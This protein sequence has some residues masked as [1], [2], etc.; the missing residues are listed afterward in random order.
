MKRYRFRLDS[1]LRVRR[2]Q[3]ERARAELLSANQAV[4]AAQTHLQQR[5]AHLEELPKSAKV[6]STPAFLANQARLASIASSISMA[7][8]AR[9]VAAHAADEKRVAWQVTAQRVEGLE[10]LD[11]RDRDEHALETQRAADQEVDDL[12]V[13]RFRTANDG[14]DRS[15]A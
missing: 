13:S 1:V 10:R 15:D 9:E 5:I 11:E 6:A 12:V 2:I 3:E 4:A 7:R 14:D 8:A